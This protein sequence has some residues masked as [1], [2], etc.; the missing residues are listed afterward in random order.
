MKSTHIWSAPKPHALLW[1]LVSAFSFVVLATVAMPLSVWATEPGDD[2][3]IDALIDQMTLEEK[4]GQLT[5]LAGGSS[6]AFN[7]KL[8]EDQFD[9]IRKGSVGSYLHVSGAEV[10]RNA[11]KVAVEESR[12]GIPLLFALDVVHG[13]STIF[14]VPLALAAS[15]DPS[16]V[17]D[18]ARVAAVE[19]A[20]SGIH[21]TFAPMIDISP[22]PRWGRIVEGAGDDPYLGS[23]LAGAQVRGFQG[24]DLADPDTV[25]ATAKH[26]VGYG[27]AI[28]GRDYNSV[29]LP[30][31]ELHEVYLPPF[32]AALEAGAGSMMGAFNDLSGT[33]MH[34]HQPLVRGLLR[35]KWGFSGVFVSD[36]AAV[37]EL[38]V[39]GVAADRVEA[40][41]KALEASV[42]MEMV[43]EAYGT[44]FLKAANAGADVDISLVDQA[45]RRVLQAKVDLGLFADPYKYHDTDR[46]TD[47]LLSAQ[48]RA[49]AREAARK[50]IVLLKNDGDVLPF[51]KNPR[52]LAV[53][54]ALANDA[55]SHLGS[56]K[57]AG[58]PDDVIT[59]L[60]GIKAAVDPSTEVVF[61]AGAAPLSDDI[62]GVRRAVRAAKRADA[63]ILVVGE[64]FDQSGE[65]RSRASIA[66]PSSQQALADA[67]LK[68]GTPVAVVLVN[69]RPLAIPDLAANAD[70]ILEAWMLGVEMGPAV[71]DVIFGDNPPGGKLPVTFPR[72]T[73]Q[74]PMTYRQLRT[75]RPATAD[76][77]P[78]S[79]SSRYIDLPIDPL[80]PF[81]HGLSYGEF[82]YT[83]LKVSQRELDSDGE[84]DISFGIKNIGDRPAEEVAQLY[85][86]DPVAS[87]ARPVKELRGIHRVQL[88]PGEEKTVSF[89]LTPA[90][91]AIW[92]NDT[93]WM[94]EQGDIELMIGSS[95]ADIRLRTTI[96]IAES[97]QSNKPATA[98]ETPSSS[99]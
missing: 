24:G 44:D 89:T 11:Q 46:E 63:V 59:I 91:L 52:R 21:W 62:S 10:L 3:D 32:Y 19:T 39:H 7:S 27:A 45:V 31:R 23:I 15:F 67:I 90:Q 47:A 35:E 93:Q 50:S 40:S 56:W 77:A 69:G 28:G 14:P 75:G 84:L 4:L 64:S 94:I 2:I 80:F 49:K 78:L 41:Q 68:T 48:H 9:R 36:W 26:F 25:M 70:A 51:A 81:G 33:P 85:I 22:D 29:Q 60:D 96:E 17:E 34:A 30:L 88:K 99:D 61:E 42:D 74:I 18:A 55:G 54:G 13:H 66:L 86:H 95:S 8:T 57:A 97:T 82:E 92:Q 98:I 79:Y 73:G 65:A 58:Q 16:V 53:I 87:T 12:L 76:E 83:A 5:Q 71:A 72:V 20:A 37:D 1:G 38:T 6:K 43:S